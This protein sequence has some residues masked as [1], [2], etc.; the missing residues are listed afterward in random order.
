LPLPSRM[1]T[2]LLTGSRGSIFKTSEAAPTHKNMIVSKSHVSWFMYTGRTAWRE[3]RC[4]YAP[5]TDADNKKPRTFAHFSSRQSTARRLNLPDVQ[6]QAGPGRL[7]DIER[8]LWT[9]LRG[10]F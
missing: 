2:S 8:W 6:M 9:E 1:D 7:F 4:S 5:Q 3:G 10:R